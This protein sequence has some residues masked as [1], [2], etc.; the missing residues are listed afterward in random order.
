MSEQQFHA[1]VM[2]EQEQRDDAG[3]TNDEA[4]AYAKEQLAIVA[5]QYDKGYLD[6]QYATWLMEPGRYPVG[7]GKMLVDLMES[8]TGLDEFL[9][10][11]K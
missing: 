4:D 6:A 9:R 2:A 5:E 8:Q 3:M 7:N 10:G 11:E 1:Q